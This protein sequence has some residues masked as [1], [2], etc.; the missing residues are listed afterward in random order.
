MPD[1]KLTSYLQR[2]TSHV[3]RRQGRGGGGSR[4]SL[5]DDERVGGEGERPQQQGGDGMMLGSRLEDKTFISGQL[6][7]LHLLHRPFT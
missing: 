6:A 2:Q 5:L 7:V 4:G 1:W 3:T